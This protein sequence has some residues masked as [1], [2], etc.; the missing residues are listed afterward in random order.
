MADQKFILPKATRILKRIIFKKV[1]AEGKR[2]YSNHFTVIINPNILNKRRLGITVSK[3]VGNAVIRNRIK[4]LVR[5]FFRHSK[6]YF[7][8]SCDF[9]FIAGKGASEINNHSLNQEFKTL[10]LKIVS[11]ES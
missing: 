7:P 8:D 1:S 6:M 11:S 3:R 5:E 4:R 9:I 2:Y 10:Q